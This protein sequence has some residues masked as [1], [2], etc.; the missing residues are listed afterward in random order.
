MQ[1]SPD[2]DHQHLEWRQQKSWIS[3]PDCRVAQDKQRTQ[4][5][6][7]PRYKWKMLQNF[8][9]KFQIRNVPTFGFVYHDTNGLNRSPVLKT[10]SFLLSAIFM[11][12]LWQGQ[13]WGKAISENPFET[14]LGE[15]FQLWMLIRTP[16][17]RDIFICV[18]DW[19]KIGWKEKTLIRCAKYS[20]KKSTLENQH[21]S[22][23][24]Y[25]WGALKENVK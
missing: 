17:K 16:S 21:L 5:L 9:Q 23:I 11:V 14:Q 13:L 1:Y 20:I 4:Y 18:C 22:L 19:H 25:T 15:G 7:I 12:I 6:L 24:M 3:Y 8:L 10:Q 2:K